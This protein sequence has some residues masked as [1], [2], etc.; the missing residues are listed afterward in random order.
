[1]GFVEFLLIATGYALAALYV[2]TALLLGFV[3]LG[4]SF[5]LLRPPAGKGLVSE[6]LRNFS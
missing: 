5:G 1:V 3:R 4:R 2:L 6:I